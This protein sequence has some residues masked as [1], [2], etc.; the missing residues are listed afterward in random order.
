MNGNKEK[1][2]IVDE[3]R[4]HRDD[5]F[6]TC[7]LKNTPYDDISK[8]ICTTTQMYG[9]Y[10]LTDACYNLYCSNG[11]RYP[12][13]TTLTKQLKVNEPLDHVETKTFSKTLIFNIL[14]LM[15]C[16]A[17]ISSITKYTNG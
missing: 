15:V 8:H 12:F 10:G 16:V 6:E 1:Q 7:D 2:K 17:F 3:Y 11:N 4:K 9:N 14:F 13:C 5:F